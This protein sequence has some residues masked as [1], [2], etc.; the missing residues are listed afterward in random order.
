MWE[1][2]VIGHLPIHGMG[3]VP[4]AAATSF[5]MLSFFG[6]SCSMCRVVLVVRT[7]GVYPTGSL[8]CVCYGDNGG[9]RHGNPV[10]SWMHD[11]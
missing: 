7:L 6:Q 10:A 4:Q 5:G 8:Q 3:A 9:R 1:G 2:I 11:S